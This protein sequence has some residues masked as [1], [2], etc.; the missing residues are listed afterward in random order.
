MENAGLMDLTYLKTLKKKDI[1]TY[2]REL[3]IALFPILAIFLI[4][5]NIFN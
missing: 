4:V 3:E 2:K 1:N 5:Q